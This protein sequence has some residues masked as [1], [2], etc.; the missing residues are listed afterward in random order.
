MRV[1]LL[2]C[3]VL[4]LGSNARAQGEPDFAPGKSAWN[5]SSRLVALARRMTATVRAPAVLDMDAVREG[6]VVFLLGPSRPLPEADLVEFVRRG[7]SLVIADDFGTAGPL[8]ARFGIRRT[9]VGSTAAARVRG[10]D[11]LLV[12]RAFYSHP[13]TEGVQAVVT[14][15]PTLLHHPRLVPLLGLDEG[16]GALVL[17]GVVGQGRVVAISD[18]SLFIDEMMAL[19]PNRTLA[20]NVLRFVLGDDPTRTLHL[21]AGDVRFT[22]DFDGSMDGPWRERLQHALST[23]AGV[24]LPDDA[25][26]VSAVLLVALSA[27]LFSSL[28]PRRTEPSLPWLAPGEAPELPGRTAEATAADLL[29]ISVERRLG[30]GPNATRKERAR[31]VD[32]LGLPPEEERRMLGALERL[33]RPS[34][35]GTPLPELRRTIGNFQDWLTRRPR[36]GGTDPR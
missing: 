8:L 12:A 21:A 28:R 22:G 7:G 33:V 25:L 18:P 29:R 5:A 6:D 15:R 16:G 23:M 30:L 26:R 14:N 3:A 35:R 36:K 34:P 32:S 24:R 31:V 9:E 4:L 27:L 19:T 2:V 17:T 20:T 10:Q 11:H 1:A 13:I